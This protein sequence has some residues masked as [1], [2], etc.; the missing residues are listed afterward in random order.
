MNYL[1]IYCNL[2]RKAEN[3]TPPEGYVEKHHI[4]PISIFGK[5]NR[6]VVLTAREHYIAHALLEK[7]CIKRYGLTH[8]RTIK[9]VF[10]HL[11]MKGDKDNVGKYYNSIL[12]EEAVKRYSL[13]ITGDLHPRRNKPY[14]WDNAIGE[15]HHMKK[16]EYRKIF[17]ERM[18]GNKNPNYGKY[19]KDNPLYGKKLSKETIEKRT[20]S[21]CKRTYNITSPTGEKYITNNL[22]EFCRNYKLNNGYMYEVVNGKR[23]DCWGWKVY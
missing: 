2:I 16:E 3:R 12:Y 17:S 11:G 10:A 5:N 7:I 23:N 4:F 18:K 1:K 15:N 14:L 13:T 21:R 20:K 19:G 9:M 22:R 8:N 6:I